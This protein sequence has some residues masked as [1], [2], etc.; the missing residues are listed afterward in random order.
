MSFIPP[1]QHQRC[2]DDYLSIPHKY[3]KL[4]RYPSTGQI[5]ISESSWKYLRHVDQWQAVGGIEVKGKGRMQTFMW[6]PPPGFHSSPVNNAILKPIKKGNGL[7][8]AVIASTLAIGHSAPLAKRRYSGPVQTLS[9]VG[10]Q[11]TLK[12]MARVGSQGCFMNQTNMTQSG[13]RSTLHSDS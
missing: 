5:H 13:S 10:S 8:S 2:Q 4:S 11:C 6:I 3:V 12:G 7:L 1:F 9:R